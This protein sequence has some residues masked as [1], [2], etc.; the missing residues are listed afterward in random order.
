MN[1]GPRRRR[2]NPERTRRSNDSGGMGPWVITILA[3]LAVIAGG[4]FLGQALARSFSRGGERTAQTASSVPAVTPLPSPTATE[5]QET[6]QPSPSA[7][8]QPA[9][10]RVAVATAPPTPS[11]APVHTSAPPAATPAPTVAPSPS[12]SPQPTAA[13][14]PVPVHTPRHIAEAPLPATPAAVQDAAESTVRAYIADLQRGDPQSAAALLGNGS[15]DEGFID[16][17]TRIE[18]V[19]ETSNADGSARVNVV[20]QT[21]QGKMLETFDVAPAAGGSRILDRITS[22]Q[23]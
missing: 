20:M 6:P 12:P 16:G 1:G 14:T 23:P 9:P 13:R 11:P 17:Q 10:T 21:S 18:S 15:P 19:S 3:A 7:S 5:L 4:W 8:P 2:P 22:K